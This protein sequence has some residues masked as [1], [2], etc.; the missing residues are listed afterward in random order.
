MKGASY[1]VC[2]NE[3]HA[4]AGNLAFT[5]LTSCLQFT[6]LNCCLMTTGPNWNFEWPN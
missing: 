2:T 3:P 5:M 4:V 1:P 6:M